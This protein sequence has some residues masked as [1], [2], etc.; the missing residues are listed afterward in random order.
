MLEFR[1]T[2]PAEGTA[3]EL[4]DCWLGDKVL[5]ED[6]HSLVEG[7]ED[8]FKAHDWSLWAATPWVGALMGSA[9]RA[10]SPLSSA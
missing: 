4:S 3:L 9:G 6:L 5:R 8:L 2:S 10:D 1:N 7:R